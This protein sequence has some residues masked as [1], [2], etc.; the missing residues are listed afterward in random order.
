VAFVFLFTN[1]Q[2]LLLWRRQAK[3]FEY[4]IRGGG[5]DGVDSEVFGPF[6][7]DQI[8]VWIKQGYF[9]GNVEIRIKIGPNK[10]RFCNAL[11]FDINHELVALDQAQ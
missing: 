11:Q 1:W 10:G 2:D 3:V 8:D 5:P 9:Q 7:G 6:S 4:V